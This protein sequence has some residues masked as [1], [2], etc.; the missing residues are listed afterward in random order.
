MGRG[1]EREQTGHHGKRSLMRQIR[2]NQ[3]SGP[4]C[5][6]AFYSHFIGAGVKFW[7]GC[8]NFSGQVQD[9]FRVNLGCYHPAL[10][11]G[12]LSKHPS[13]SSLKGDA[14]LKVCLREKKR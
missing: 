5:V 12:F 1:C 7:S 10:F 9:V 13:P 11:Q 8:V 2:R 6:Y 4:T 14:W 3:I